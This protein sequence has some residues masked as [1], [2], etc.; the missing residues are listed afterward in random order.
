MKCAE[1]AQE[2]RIYKGFLKSRH[3]RKRYERLTVE[4]NFNAFYGK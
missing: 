1:T 4:G 2:Q 3:Q